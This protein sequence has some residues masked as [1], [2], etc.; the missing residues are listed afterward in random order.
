VAGLW[1]D[2]GVYTSPRNI[3]RTN[4]PCRSLRRGFC[5]EPLQTQSWTHMGF[6]RSM[7]GM[8]RQHL[9]Q[10]CLKGSSSVAGM[11]DGRKCWRPGR[12]ERQVHRSCD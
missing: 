7:I 9:T 6:L 10:D 12:P 2:T 5:F 11:G 1:R 8:S 3:H 4:S